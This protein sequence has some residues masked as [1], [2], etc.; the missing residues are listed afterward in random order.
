MLILVLIGI[1]SRMARPQGILVAGVLV[2]LLRRLKTSFL[3][4]KIPDYV[5][6]IKAFLTY[7]FLIGHSIAI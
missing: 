1:P 4:N 6:N 3:V 5:F 2:S 7:H